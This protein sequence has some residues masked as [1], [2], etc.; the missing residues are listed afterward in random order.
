MWE[1]AELIEYSSVSCSWVYFWP[2]PV[3]FPTL[4]ITSRRHLSGDILR[5]ES[6]PWYVWGS[7]ANDLISLCFQFYKCESDE[8]PSSLSVL[9]WSALN[10]WKSRSRRDNVRRS[11]LRFNALAS[12]SQA[13]NCGW[14]GGTGGACASTASGCWTFIFTLALTTDFLLYSFRVK[15]S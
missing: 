6:E 12:A 15:I 5:F 2:S 8:Y 11:P 9:H 13:G 1:V 10:S 3:R 7:L 4:M 14:T